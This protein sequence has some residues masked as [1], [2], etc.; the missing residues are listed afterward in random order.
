MKYFTKFF[1]LGCVALVAMLLTAPGAFS[2]TATT[3]Y[4]D[5]VN[6]SGTAC[7]VITTP[8]TLD[9][10][11]TASSNGDIIAVRVRRAGGSVT[12][13]GDPTLPVVNKDITFAT[14]QRGTEGFVKGILNFTDEV[15]IATNSNAKFRRHKDVTVQFKD[16]N[17]FGI[18][19]PFASAVADQGSFTI[20]GTWST[21]GNVR[22]GSLVVDSDITMKGVTD[23]DGTAIAAGAAAPIIVVDA[24]EIKAGATLTI[25]TK[26]ETDATHHR[27]DLRV[28]LKKLAAARAMDAKGADMGNLIVN[29]NIDGEGE[30]WIAHLETGEDR[31][32]TGTPP[33]HNFHVPGDYMPDAMGKIDHEDCVM[34]SG[35]GSILVKTTAVAAGNVCITLDEMGDLVAAGSIEG[36]GV[37]ATTDIIFRNPVMID[38]SVHQWGDARVVFEKKAMIDGGVI[39]NNGTVSV[40]VVPADFGDVASGTVANLTDADSDEHYARTVTLKTAGMAEVPANNGPDGQPGTDDDVAAVP[41]KSPVY[42]T[43]TEEMD[44][45]RSAA[46]IVFSGVQFMADGNMIEGDLSLRYT[47]NTVRNQGPALRTVEDGFAHLEICET[48]AIFWAGAKKGAPMST[49]GGDLSIEAGGTVRLDGASVGTPAKPEYAAHSLNIDGDIF[50]DGPMG[51]SITMGSPAMSSI[52]GTCEMGDLMLGGGNRV[53]LTSMND[54]VVSVGSEGLTIETLVLQQ[55]LDIQGSGNLTSSTVH[56]GAGGELVSNGKAK[57]T[58]DLIL[59]GKGIDGA[60][61]TGSNVTK[62]AYASTRGEIPLS[63]LEVLSV[64]SGR[65]LRVENPLTVDVLGL[66]SGDVTLVD[67]GN[68]KT[69][70]LTVNTAIHVKDGKITMDANAPGDLVGDGGEK[71]AAGD[72]YILRYVTEGERTVG[73]ELMGARDLV[74]DH[75]MAKVTV[76]DDLSLG[77][78]LHIVNGNLSV[79][80]DLTVGASNLAADRF[81][82]IHA[83]AEL[84]SNGNNVVTHAMVTVDGKLMTGDGDL[85]VL[86][87]N[88]PT[89]K[90]YVDGTAMAVVGA[91]GVIDVGMGTLQLGP[92]FDEPTNGLAGDDRRDV[93]LT[94]AKGGMVKGMIDV[95]KG[96]K[97]TS[98][99]GEAFDV[100]VLDGTGNPKKDAKGADNWGG[101]LFFHDT[102]VVIDSLAAMNDAAVEFYDDVNPTAEGDSI[103]IKKDVVLKS[104]RIYVNQ[105][106]TL[107]FGGDLMIRDTGG[108]TVWNNAKVTVDGDFVQDE[109]KKHAGDQDGTKLPHDAVF[110]VMGDFMVADSASRY[111]SGAGAKLVLKGDFSFGAV[112]MGSKK[113]LNAMLEFSGKKSQS[114]MSSV[115]LGDVVVNNSMGLTLGSDVMQGKMNTLTLTRGVISS[116]DDASGKDDDMM[117]TWT[118]TNTGIEEDVRGRNNAFE[119]CDM[120][121]EMCDS[122]IKKGSRSSH[123]AAGISRLVMHGNSGG[124]E[125]SGGYLFP[126][127]G[128]DGD[129]A[130]YRPLILQLPDDLSDADTVTVSPEMVP[131]GAMPAWPAE[132]ILV[133]VQ[134][135][136]LTLDAHADIFWKVELKEAMDQNPHIR[137]AAGGLANVFDPDGIRLVQWDCD[138]SNPRLAGTAIVGEDE[139]SFAENGYVNGVLNLTQMSVEVGTCAIL[140][141]A[142]NGLENPIHM[143]AL[144]GGL[145]RVQFIHNVPL[146]APVDLSLDGVRLQSGL[147]FRNATGYAVV[148]AGAHS[149]SIQVAGAPADQAITFDL[150]T[151]AHESSY[152]VIA[153]G[154]ATAPMV[155]I[156]E[157]RM[158]SLADNMVD[159]ILVHGSADLGTVDVRTVGTTP[160]HEATKLLANNIKFGDATNYLALEP[161]LHNLQVKSA[162]GEEEIDVFEVSLNGYEGETVIL[163]LSGT[164]NV[165]AIGFEIFG[166]DIRGDRISTQTVTSVVDEIA[167][168]PTEFALHGNYP[169]P[170]N[171]STRIQFDLPES[172]QVTLQVV[173]MLGREVMILPAKEFEAGANRSMEIN[174]VN[175]ASGTYL[176]RMIATGAESRYVK[177]GRMTLVK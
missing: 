46:A 11:L 166:V 84:N 154:A 78:K 35:S 29:G 109:G 56:V 172:A 91:K 14:Y 144:T 135:G 126:V 148:A 79:M 40:D 113:M 93:S 156:L 28:P 64:S 52:M 127:G 159:A 33:V 25:G 100:I 104:A 160:D 21:G 145:S 149:A 105:N 41:A 44:M 153:H 131:E 164:K 110:T 27:I 57:V 15:V 85:H 30:L 38:G 117:H 141:V 116:M 50:V 87:N 170:F 67:T 146:P 143:D 2:Q 31:S 45:R 124:G 176:Y 71:A 20:S 16:V 168:L 142:A 90:L 130:Y 54:H 47:T 73:A 63:S 39:L 49:V 58:S 96:S 125:T 37:I 89:N 76:M 80:G 107:K 72:G 94:V 97:K 61:A 111:E 150:P 69:N 174:A 86:G 88:H 22:Y 10:A 132:N 59:Q 81:V 167:E 9:A 129:M 122:V 6:G 26:G 19:D 24:L 62:L 112:K 140:G 102:K 99:T 83:G 43:C 157:T 114:V 68:D 173:D 95:P 8:C 13:A 12:I 60:L 162:Q 120:S 133:P 82:N 1:G 36:T 119:N 152:A 101:G 139:E 103:T 51:G 7:D 158:T 175:L 77:G 55:K 4:V 123:V 169:N 17:T 138:W 92:S 66:C 147:E 177:T 23:V 108:I 75:K 161:G 151:L 74:L 136:L 134:G 32:T 70:S 34:I 137:V 3:R 48:Q 155:E 53:T 163:N 5:T 65:G 128:M 18:S 118:V 98:I 121:T 42:H 171:P 165:M 106:N 115:H